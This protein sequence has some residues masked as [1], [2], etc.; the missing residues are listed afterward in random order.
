MKKFNLDV[1]YELSKE[2]A[3]GKAYTPE[4]LSEGNAQLTNNYIETAVITVNRDGLDSQFRRL[5]VKIQ[6]K[7][8]TALNTGEYEIEF[9]DGEFNFIKDAV[10]NAKFNATIAKYVVALEDAILSV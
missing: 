6:S 4:E 10:I 5:W 8:Q 2:N 1:N 7:I 3:E 9:E